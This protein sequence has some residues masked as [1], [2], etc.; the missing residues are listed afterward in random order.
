MAGFLFRGNLTDRSA[1]WVGSGAARETSVFPLCT[2]GS[3]SAASGHDRADCLFSV[4]GPV[5]GIAQQ[6]AEGGDTEIVGMAEGRVE[7]FATTGADVCPRDGF[8]P[9]FPT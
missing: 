6:G 4:D 2:S 5:N 3:G 7:H 8:A 9:V 1:V